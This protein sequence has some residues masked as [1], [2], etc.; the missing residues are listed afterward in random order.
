MIQG[1]PLMH[2]IAAKAIAFNE[3]LQPSFIEYQKQILKT[4]NIWQNV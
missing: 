3:A 2:I 4:L 1:G